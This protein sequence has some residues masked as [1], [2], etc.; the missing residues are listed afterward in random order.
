MIHKLT[1][2]EI[3]KLNLILQNNFHSSVN[4]DDPFIQYWIYGQEEILG[5]ISYSNLY[6][7]FDL[8][9][10]WVEEKSRKSGI[11]SSLMN[12]MIEQAHNS[13]VSTITLEVCETNESAI[14]LYEKFGFVKKTIRKNYYGDKNGILM[15]LEVR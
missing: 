13:H 7:S 8:N 3:E 1:N 11:A 2:S 14:K 6:D 9:Y 12:V 15:L 5:F 4:L 10:I